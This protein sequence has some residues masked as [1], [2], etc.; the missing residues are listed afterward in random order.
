MSCLS[1]LR[2]RR[3]AEVSKA[4]A[5]SASVVNDGCVKPRSIR[6]INARTEGVSNIIRF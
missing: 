3:C 2:T 5:K 1:N 4:F 6:D